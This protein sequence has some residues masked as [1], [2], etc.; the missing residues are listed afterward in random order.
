LAALCLTAALPATAHAQAPGEPRV[1]IAGGYVFLQ[2]PMSTSVET[3]TYEV[4]WLAAGTCRLGSGRWSAAGEFGI[5]SHTNAFDEHQRL[6]GL[7]G[8]VRVAVY[9]RTR[10]TLFAQV[11]AGLERFSEPGLAQSGPAVQPGAGVDMYVSRTVFL[12]AQG[13]YRWSQ[14]GGTTFHAYRVVGAIGVAIR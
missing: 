12:R 7:E 3:P 1:S 13:D 2:Q 6:M 14:S 5:S 9:S 10:V 8:G 4:G 11:L